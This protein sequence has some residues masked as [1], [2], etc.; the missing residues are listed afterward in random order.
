MI[1]SLVLS[2]LYFCDVCVSAALLHSDGQ[3]L[4]LQT[5]QQLH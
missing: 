4:H 2:N 3:R 5:D 1:V